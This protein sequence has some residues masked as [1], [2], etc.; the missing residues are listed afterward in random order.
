MK[1]D[2]SNPVE[3]WVFVGQ[4]HEGRQFFVSLHNPTRLKI[5]SKIHSIE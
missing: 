4:D 2:V 5:D 3:E 1:S